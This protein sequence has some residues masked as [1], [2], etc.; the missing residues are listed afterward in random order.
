MAI[1]T[2]TRTIRIDQA[3]D[4]AIQKYARDEKISANFLINRAL[5]AYLEW[6]IAVQKFGLSTIQ[7]SQLIKLIAPFDDNECKAMGAWAARESFK[8]L[9]EHQFSRL[10]FEASIEILR[11]FSEYGRCYEF[12]YVSVGKRHTLFIKHSS[13]TKWSYYYNGL[14]KAVFEGMLGLKV[15]FEF[16]EELC[17]AQID[18]G[19]I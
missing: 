19:I 11:R 5:R 3:A 1:H 4:D 12:D 18:L 7:K 13:G 10:D 6:Q 17:I 15:D 16:T 2:V 14:I 8:P 9:A